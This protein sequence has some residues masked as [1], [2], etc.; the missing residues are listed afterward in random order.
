MTDGPQLTGDALKAVRHRGSHVQ[1]IASA[2]SGKTE[3]I[4]QRVVD[5]L[6]EGIPPAAIV[7]FTFTEKAAESL[8]GRIQ[9][10]AAERLGDEAVGR[11]APMYVGTIHAYCFRLLQTRVSRY[12]AFDVLDEHQ[13]AAF[14]A[15]EGRSLDIKRIDPNGRLF[16]SIKTFLANVDVVENELI[17]T[18]VVEEPFRSIYR[19]Y[20]ER[21]EA[22]RALTFGQ[23][24]VR[25]VRELTQPEVRDAV[26]GDLRHL[27]VDEYQDIN[28][29]QERLIELLAGPGVE[30]CVVGDDDQAVYQWRGTDVRNIV[31]FTNRYPGTATFTIDVNRRSRPGIIALANECSSRIERRLPK[32]MKPDRPAFTDDVVV[33]SANDEREQAQ[34]IARAIHA[35]H[36][37]GHRYS[38]IAILLRSRTSLAAHSRGPRRRRHP[39]RPGRSHQPVPAAGRPALWAAVRLAG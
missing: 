2:G 39:G 26:L 18:G 29:A 33:W 4:A 12:E 28:P 30:L 6:A 31:E 1:I 16:A 8:K 15:R 14:L 35:A 3:V 10:R 17:A 13:L 34:T 36:A 37:A 22:F 5:L 27:I 38:D 11:L 24:T 20:L 32:A 9:R 25:A 21:L 7:A 19:E 23:I